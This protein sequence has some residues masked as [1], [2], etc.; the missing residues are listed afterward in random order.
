MRPRA[1][2]CSI[3]EVHGSV[4]VLRVMRLADVKTDGWVVLFG[5]IRSKYLSEKECEAS[6]RSLAARIPNTSTA[7]PIVCV[8]VYIYSVRTCERVCD[9]FHVL[10]L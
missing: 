5:C 8:C 10:L 6:S 1:F 9:I 2:S 7:E 3:A 4:V